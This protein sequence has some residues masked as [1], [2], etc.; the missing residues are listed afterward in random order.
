VILRYNRLLIFFLFLAFCSRAG[1][2]QNLTANIGGGYVGNLFADSFNI[3]NSFI[4]NNVSFSSTSFQKIKLKL[5]YGISYYNYNTDNPINNIF[6]VPGVTLYKKNQDG[7]FKWGIDTFATIKD[8]VSA[9]SSFDNYRIFTV[10]DVSYYLVPGFQAR[11]LY[12]L[13]RSKY[14]SYGVL[15][16]IEQSAEAGIVATLPHRTTLRGTGRYSARRFDTDQITFHWVDTEFGLS[17]SID[18]R[19]GLSFTFLKRWSKGGERPLASYYI[20]SG[21]TSYWDPW[22]GNQVEIALKRILPYAILCKIVGGSWNKSFLYDQY[23]RDQ[24]SW[25]KNKSGRRDEG[26]L[27]RAE[28]GRQYG[29]RLPVTESIKINMRGG[30]LSNHS[31]DRFYTYNNFMADLNLEIHIF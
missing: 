14:L 18:I 22:S 27:V 25:L 24:L 26:W 4:W 28:L 15:D 19:T 12:S 8:Y 10:A 21:I 9:N 16:N 7:R 13:T 17:Q 6:H 3:G 23:L 31:G 29:L 11:T 1:A 5:Y 20:I 30:Y 2:Y